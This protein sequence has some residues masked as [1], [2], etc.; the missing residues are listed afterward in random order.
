MVDVGGEK[1]LHTASSRLLVRM[2]LF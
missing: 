1:L 2:G